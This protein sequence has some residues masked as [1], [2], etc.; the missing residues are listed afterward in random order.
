MDLDEESFLELGFGSS[1]D[2]QIQCV[3]ER[4]GAVAAAQSNRR[5]VV[6][7]KRTLPQSSETKS[8]RMQSRREMRALRKLIVKGIYDGVGNRA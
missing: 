3:Y 2:E 1:F 7:D 5:R 6:F 8:K 4:R